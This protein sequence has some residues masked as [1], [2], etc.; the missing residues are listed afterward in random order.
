MS[1]CEA[2]Y[3][4]HYGIKGQKKGVRR[5]QYEDGTLTEEGKRR[6]GK[7]IRPDFAK[8]LNDSGVADRISEKQAAYLQNY[9]TGSRKSIIKYMQTHPKSTFEDAD[10]HDTQKNLLIGL[11]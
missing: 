11:G 1:Y 5:F 9:T 10:R 4:I 6:Y 7:N 3:L 8:Y 2:S